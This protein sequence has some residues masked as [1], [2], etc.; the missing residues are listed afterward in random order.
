[1]VLKRYE[2]DEPRETFMTTDEVLYETSYEKN[3][4][5]KSI[6]TILKQAAVD[7]EIHRK[8]HSK[9]RPVIQCMRFDTKTKGD[10]LAFKPSYKIDELDKSYIRN[11]QRKNR[12]LQI[13]KVK[14]LLFVIDPDTNEVFDYPCFIE[15][16]RLLRI[17]NRISQTK[18][19]FFTSVIS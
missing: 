13:I 15:S 6:S 2:G 16:K 5:I 18:I 11:I 8:L 10:D 14:E 3:R 9:E 4:L 17:G 19:E 7:C 12:R 1:M